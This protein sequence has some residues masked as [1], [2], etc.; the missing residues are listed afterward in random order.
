M[1]IF[2]TVYKRSSCSIGSISY[3]LL[4]NIK[5]C[6]QKHED[7]YEFNAI[8]VDVQTLNLI[9]HIRVYVFGNIALLSFLLFIHICIY[10]SA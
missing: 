8:K 5:V 3:L 9:S 2:M 4:A 10:T 6:T 1:M 7:D